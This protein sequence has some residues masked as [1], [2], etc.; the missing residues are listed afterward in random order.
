M[1]GLSAASARRLDGAH[2]LLMKLFR[3]VA[4]EASIAVLDGQRGRAAQERAFAL[5]HSRAHF[6][7]SAHNFSPAVALDVVPWP[8]DWSDIARF[9]SLA[10]LVKAKAVALGVPIAWGGDWAKLRDM[11]HYELNP[12]RTF[13]AEGRPFDG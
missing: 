2:P 7:Q 3:A 6:G 1:T 5:G 10:E 9:R 4:A 12:W 11:P 8:L 13:A